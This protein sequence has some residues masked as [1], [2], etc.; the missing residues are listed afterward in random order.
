MFVLQMFPKEISELELTDDEKITLEMAQKF[1]LGEY[2]DPI[3][4]HYHVFTI[5]KNKSGD[6]KY[7][8]ED[9]RERSKKISD[10]TFEKTSSQLVPSLKHFG[11]MMSILLKLSEKAFKIE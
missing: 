8:L 1:I 6:L 10:K 9:A 5:W 2:V 4:E 3:D 11:S 7:T